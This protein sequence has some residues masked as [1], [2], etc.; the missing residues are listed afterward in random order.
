M[1]KISQIIFIFLMFILSFSQAFG[2]EYWQCEKI[3]G[4]GSLFF[5]DESSCDISSHHPYQRCKTDTCKK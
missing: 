3:E 2:E 5:N 1:K 4:S